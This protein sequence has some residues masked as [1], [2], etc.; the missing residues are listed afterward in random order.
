MRCLLLSALACL[1][2]LPAAAQTFQ[3]PL[4][5]SGADPWVAERDGVYYYMQ[6]TGRNLTIWKTRDVTDL[7]HA[8]K[9]VVWT[10]PAAGPYSKEIWAPELHWL[11]GK[12][13]LY[14]AADAGDNDGHRIWVLENAS[15]DPTK[16]A[17]TMK[18][19]LDD[20]SDKWA[21]DPSVFTAGGRDYVIWSGWQGDT[22]GVQSIY[23]AQLRNPWTIEGRRVRISTPEYPW[24][25]VGD[26]DSQNRII[27]MPHVD[28]NEGPE[29]LEHGDRIFLIYSAS[30]C[31]TNYY[32]LGMLTAEKSSDLLDP[33]SWKKSPKPV[34]WQSPEAQAFGT[35]HN[36]FFQSP[37]G[38]QDWILYHANAGVNQSCGGDRSPRAQPFT[39]NA[40]GTPDFGR[41]IPLDQPIQ[42][43]SGTKE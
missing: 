34:F 10:P 13:Y 18:G 16:G 26:L 12:W 39:W 6:T 17:W 20:G 37:D 3:N 11:D 41:P 43:P 42:K 31:W 1:F 22:N 7:R 32:E 36:T 29:I 14:F 2:A 25:K 5:P 33:K 9:T 19:K 8:E 24:E 35:G 40:D 4:L 38:R 27:P 21:I 30:G 28:V 15:A 23:I